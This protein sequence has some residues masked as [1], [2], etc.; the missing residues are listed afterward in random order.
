MPPKGF[1]SL[2][3]DDETAQTLDAIADALGE[4]ISR[5]EAASRAAD[6][7]AEEVGA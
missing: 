4:D 5:A 1:N 3:I 7:Y 2:S 6:A